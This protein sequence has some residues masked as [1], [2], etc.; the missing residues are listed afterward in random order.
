[1]NVFL[2]SLIQKKV[3]R[4]KLWRFV[5]ALIILI[6][7]ALLVASILLLPSYFVLLFSVEQIDRRVVIEEQV[8]ARRDLV[9]LESRVR[10]INSKIESFEKNESFRYSL[11]SLLYILGEDTKTGIE[12]SNMTLRTTGEG[13]AFVMQIQGIADT[14]DRLVSYIETLRLRE[15]FVSVFSPISNFLEETNVEFSLEVTVNEKVYAYKAK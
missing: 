8:L 6:G 7:F 5:L 1:M 14:R 9:S 12:I 2:P 13:G 11:S 3:M 4:A 15:E 10:S